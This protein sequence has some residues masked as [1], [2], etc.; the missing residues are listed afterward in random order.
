MM[1]G[2]RRQHLHQEWQGPLEELGYYGKITTLEVEPTGRQATLVSG[3]WWALLI[4][5]VLA[6]CG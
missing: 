1:E 3:A 5:C 6:S 4:M 2:P